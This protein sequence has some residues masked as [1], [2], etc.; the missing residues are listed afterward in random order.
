M[1]YLA[2]FLILLGAV[3]RVVPHPANFAPIAG[4]A[5]FGGAK[6]GKKQALVVPLAAMLLSDAFI[7]FDSWTSRLVIYGTF[8]AVGLIG[9]WLRS[10]ASA[11]NVVGASLVSSVLFFLVTNL[12]FVHSFSMYPQTWDG[13]VASYINGLPFFRNTLAGDLIYTAAFFGLYAL[14]AAW[15]KQRADVTA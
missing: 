15:Q 11:V 12:P 10:R 6:L 2:Y 9:L 14:A 13:V 5:L 7:G 3:M 8:L 1:S 4:L